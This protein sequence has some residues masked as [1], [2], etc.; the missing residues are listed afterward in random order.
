MPVPESVKSAVNYIGDMTMPLSMLIIGAL[1]STAKIKEL[2]ND[3]RVYYVSAVRLILMPLLAYGILYLLG[4]PEQIVS[5]I[6][7][8]LAMP[9]AATTTIFADLFDKD[10]VFASKAVMVSTILS[11]IT[12][13]VI[14]ALL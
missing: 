3:A 14:V 13:P 9:V 6:V 8:A 10:A 7:T 1:I 5:I 4:V 2:V 12:A 11:V